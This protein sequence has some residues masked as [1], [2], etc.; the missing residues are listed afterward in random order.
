L[1]YQKQNEPR[2]RHGITIRVFT[3]AGLPPDPTEFAVTVGRAAARNAR[4]LSGHTAG[5]TICVVSI[6]AVT[7]PEAAPSAPAAVAALRIGD[8]ELSLS[9]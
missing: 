9:L 7:G 3:E 4:I 8:A 1:R 5:E 2:R 6:P